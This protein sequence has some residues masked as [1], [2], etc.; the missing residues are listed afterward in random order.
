M[1]WRRDFQNP[2][3]PQTKTGS[4]LMMVEQLTFL[5][6]HPRKNVPGR[7]SGLLGREKREATRKRQDH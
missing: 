5:L 7:R 2:N 6:D 4:G 1:H 3:P